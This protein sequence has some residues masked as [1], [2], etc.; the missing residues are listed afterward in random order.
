MLLAMADYMP[1]SLAVIPY[2][3]LAFAKVLSLSEDKNQGGGCVYVKW[4]PGI[5]RGL[6]LQ[7]C[8]ETK[9]LGCS[10]SF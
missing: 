6:T 4:S 1:T 3:I 10:S 2:K 5:Y 7:P 9:I 8:T